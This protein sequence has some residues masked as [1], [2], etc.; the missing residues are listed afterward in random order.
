MS[1]P[2]ALE[3]AV[4]AEGHRARIV[5]A[6]APLQ[7]RRR[8]KRRRPSACER[9]PGIC[10]P[11]ET[12][13]DK[14]VALEELSAGDA[15]VLRKDDGLILRDMG[16]DARGPDPWA[17]AKRNRGISVAHKCSTISSQRAASP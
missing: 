11:A 7:A 1:G 14:Q 8:G 4:A 10:A 5:R 17:V 9:N 2:V 13:S 12:N 6:V 15:A 3:R 16:L